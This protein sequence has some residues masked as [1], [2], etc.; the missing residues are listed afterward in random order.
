MT[1]HLQFTAQACTS[2]VE[3]EMEKQDWNNI[4]KQSIDSSV[5]LSWKPYAPYN[6]EEDYSRFVLGLVAWGDGG[7]WY[8]LRGLS[9]ICV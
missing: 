6:Y 2:G 4:I 9:K 3:K 7:W 8:L 5:G 1:S